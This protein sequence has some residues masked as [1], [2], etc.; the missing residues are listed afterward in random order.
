[1]ASNNQGGFPNPFDPIIQIINSATGILKDFLAPVK[2]IGDFFATLDQWITNPTRIV[3]L[4]A[5]LGLVGIAT[6]VTLGAA[7]RGIAESAPG[8]TATRAAQS[9]AGEHVKAEQEA[10][11]ERIKDA[12]RQARRA[13]KK[14]QADH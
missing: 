13:S 12:N 6:L 2:A 9:L 8:Q 10:E 7:S 3:K 4:V 1:M 5:G 11:Q 14:M